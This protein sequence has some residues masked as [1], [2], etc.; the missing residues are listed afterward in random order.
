MLIDVL[1]RF[2]I[3][4]K[5]KSNHT[6]KNRLLSILVKSRLLNNLINMRGT[7]ENIIIKL[8]ALDYTVHVHKESTFTP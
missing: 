5:I 7:E 6:K 3:A 2:Y 1:I 8:Y 4:F